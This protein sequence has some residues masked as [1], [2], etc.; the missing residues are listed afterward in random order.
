MGKVD[1][2]PLFVYLG[3][4]TDQLHEFRREVSKNRA[5]NIELKDEINR[6]AIIMSATA[7]VIDSLSKRVKALELMEIYNDQDCERVDIQTLGLD[8]K[9][10]VKR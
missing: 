6:L 4:L 2:K 7:E 9:F 8:G 5:S 3:E 10:R 1:E